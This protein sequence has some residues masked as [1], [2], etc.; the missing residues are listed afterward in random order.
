MVPSVE[1]CHGW[2]GG[3]EELV[4]LCELI[5]RE[6]GEAGTDEIGDQDEG[7]EER[8]AANGLWADTGGH[9]DSAWMNDDNQLDDC[10]EYMY[11]HAAACTR[12]ENEVKDLEQRDYL[13][14]PTLIKE[15]RPL[16]PKALRIGP[17]SAFSS[18]ASS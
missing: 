13:V 3:G 1:V 18:F 12:F 6:E 14:R 8:D 2:S 4:Q 17:K 5:G 11:F 10:V 16:N 7:V 9:T 15:D